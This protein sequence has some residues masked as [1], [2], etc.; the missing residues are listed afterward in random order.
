MEMLVAKD[1]WESKE[2]KEA[3]GSLVLGGYLV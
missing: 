3:R 2:L 1:M